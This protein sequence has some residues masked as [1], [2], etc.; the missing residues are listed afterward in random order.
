VC[1]CVVVFAAI[2]P[3]QGGVLACR[4]RF[5]LLLFFLEIKNK[6]SGVVL[7]IGNRECTRIAGVVQGLVCMCVCVSDFYFFL[8][9]GKTPTPGAMSVTS[10]AHLSVTSV[11]LLLCFR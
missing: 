11:P 10:E 6:T 8:I 3:A 7:E 5:L 1:V 2:H 9:R 4:L